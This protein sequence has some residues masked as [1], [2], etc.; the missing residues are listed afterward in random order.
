MHG[1]LPQPSEFSVMKRLIHAEQTVDRPV[2]EPLTR[3][4]EYT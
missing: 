2:I 4:S 1:V 3:M